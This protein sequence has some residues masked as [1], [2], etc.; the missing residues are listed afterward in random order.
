MKTYNEKFLYIK[1]W[2]ADE[3]SNPL[4][5]ED[6]IKLTLVFKKRIYYENA[7]LI[8]LGKILFKRA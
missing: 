2:F 8:D 7:S 5:V 6:R 1:V 3:N 4:E